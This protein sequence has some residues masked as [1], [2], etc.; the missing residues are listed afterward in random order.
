MAA[1]LGVFAT[2]SG[3]L[4]AARG[5]RLPLALAGPAL[6]VG[7]L[8]FVA[9]GVHTSV[10]Y[11]IVADLIFGTGS[12]LVAAP[13]TNTALSGMPAAQAGVAGAIASTSRQFGAALGVAVVGAIVAGDSRAGFT[14]ASPGA[15]AVIAAWR[16]GAGARPRLDGSLGPAHRETQGRATHRPPAR[17]GAG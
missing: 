14:T 6:A 9:L 4:V 3:R 7:A 15:W 2:V 8:M 10:W 11:L 13:I 1:M 5:P 17:G 12:G 16:G